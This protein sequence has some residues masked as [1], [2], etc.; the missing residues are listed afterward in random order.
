MVALIAHLRKRGL[1][2]GATRKGKRQRRTSVSVYSMI[3]KSSRAQ[4]DRVNVYMIGSGFEKV[5]NGFSTHQD[6]V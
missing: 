2:S 3:T 5:K 4:D 6:E 1:L